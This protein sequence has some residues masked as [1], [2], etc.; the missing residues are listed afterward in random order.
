MRSKGESDMKNSVMKRYRSAHP[1]VAIPSVFAAAGVL[2]IFATVLMS[3]VSNPPAVT[4]NV[5]VDRLL[6]Q[7]TLDEKISLIHGGP[8]AQPSGIGGAGTWPGLPRLGI[9]DEEPT[10]LSQPSA[11]QV[12]I[13]CC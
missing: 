13:V 10:R 3:Q 7:M 11:R 1:A 4:G 6:S 2:A 9:P 8:E 12:Q 5:R